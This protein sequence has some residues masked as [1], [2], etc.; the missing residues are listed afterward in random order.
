MSPNQTQADHRGPLARIARWCIGHRKTVLVIWVVA[1]VG[2]LAVSNAV[3]TNYANNSSSGNTESQRATDLLTHSFPAQAGDT[4]Q[5]VL[6][7][8][9]GA[10]ADPRIRSRVVPML[11]KVARLPHVTGVASPYTKVGADQISPDGKIAFTAEPR[12]ASTS[13]EGGTGVVRPSN[14]SRAAASKPSPSARECHSAASDSTG[15]P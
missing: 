2:V 7:A 11:A 4:D 9:A 1:L 8:R 13:R 5:I 15:T 6:H 14:L 3:G 10:L 12:M